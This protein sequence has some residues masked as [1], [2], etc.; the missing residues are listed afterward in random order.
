MQS[1]PVP[2]AP[3][4]Q[5]ASQPGAAELKQPTTPAV[6]EEPKKAPPEV[7]TLELDTEPRTTSGAIHPEVRPHAF[8]IMPFGK[9]KSADGTFLFDFNAIYSQIIKPALEMAG[10][11]AF[12]ADE[13]K[14]SG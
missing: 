13:E 2:A 3:D 10:F 9:K 1:T 14:T 12:R 11:E 6:P 8:V 5:Q 4:S 7:K